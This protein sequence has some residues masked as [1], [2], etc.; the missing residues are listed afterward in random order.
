MS[1]FRTAIVLTEGGNY[2][3]I[4]SR[5]CVADSALVVAANADMANA[6]ADR[7][8]CEYEFAHQ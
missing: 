6:L 8:I 3:A 1:T 7:K 5:V 2:M 4:A